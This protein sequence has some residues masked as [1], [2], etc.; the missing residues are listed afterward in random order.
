M[1]FVPWYFWNESIKVAF[2]YMTAYRLLIILNFTWGI[3]SL[4]H[5]Y[6]YKPYDK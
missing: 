4:A 2:F 3:N 1:M 6:G 5:M